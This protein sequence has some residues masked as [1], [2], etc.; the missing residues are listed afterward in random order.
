MEW[1]Q[2]TISKL[3]SDKIK[4]L[5]ENAKKLREQ[6][7][8]DLCDLELLKRAPIKAKKAPSS[9]S[10]QNSRPDGVVAGFH[11]V[12]PGEKGVTRNTDG[13]I[14][15]GIW[16]VDKAHAEKALKVDAYVALHTAK[17]EPSYLQGK[18]KDWRAKKRERQ[19]ADDRLVKIEDGIEFQF[20]P[21]HEPYT[22]HG[23]GSGEKGYYWI[24]PVREDTSS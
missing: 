1:N 12:C 22:W 3:A 11:F 16:V 19:Y 2:E 7:I 17:S 10:K 23:D 4:S 18:I 15:T 13:T 24:F 8:V 20:S 14:W 6:A 5:R 21:T 9:K